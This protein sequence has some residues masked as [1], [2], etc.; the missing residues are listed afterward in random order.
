MASEKLKKECWIRQNTI[1]EPT[2]SEIVE[3]YKSLGF[4]VHLEPLAP[5]EMGGNCKQCFER[6]LGNC[7][8][9]YTRKKKEN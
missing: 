7:R 6:A 4:E 2:A 3:L 5:Q 9:A 8:T 1:D